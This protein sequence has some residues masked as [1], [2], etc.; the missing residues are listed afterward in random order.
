MPNPLTN[1]I[2]VGGVVDSSPHAYFDRL[3]ARPDHWKSY[4]LRSA[5]QVKQ[6]RQGSYVDVD[7]VFPTDPDPRKQDAAK[8]TVPDFPVFNDPS[9]NP[10][11]LAAPMSAADDTIKAWWLRNG[12]N[13][14]YKID[15]EVML[16]REKLADGSGSRVWRGQHGTAVVPHA[17]GAKVGFGFNGIRSQLYLPMGTEEGHSYLTTWDAWYGKETKYPRSGL[18]GWKN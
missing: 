12:P 16:Y 1:P 5:A 14:Y 18:S 3:V 6:Y 7:Y 15:N 11:Q 10:V 2:I 9:G 4:S 8:V 13:V 17:A